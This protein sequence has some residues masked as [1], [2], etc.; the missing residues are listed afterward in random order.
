MARLPIRWIAARAYCQAT[1]EEERVD[2]TL[3]AVVVGGTRGRETLEGQ[4]GNPIILLTRRLDARGDLD[5]T[6][7]RWRE[8]GLPREISRDLESRTDRDAVLHLRLDKQEAYAGRL[9][10]ARDSDAIDV[11]VKVEAYPSKP[12]VV[13]Q[14][15]RGLLE[16]AV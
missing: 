13:L 14:A 2:R 9:R 5:A 11:Q 8:A 7:S 10:L 15:A 16:G 12:E 3:D 6:W 1:E 4:F